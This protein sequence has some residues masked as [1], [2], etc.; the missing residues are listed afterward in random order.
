VLSICFHVLYKSFYHNPLNYD[1]FYD[2]KSLNKDLRQEVE[3]YFREELVNQV[4]AMINR[5]IPPAGI[6]VKEGSKR[7]IGIRIADKKARNYYDSYSNLQ[8]NNPEVKNITKSLDDILKNLLKK[9]S[10][11]DIYYNL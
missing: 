6:K 8:K 3:S 10:F 7:M 11:S 9:G 2:P 4:S 5:K 1:V